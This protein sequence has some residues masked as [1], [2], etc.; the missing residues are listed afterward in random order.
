MGKTELIKAVAAKAETTIKNANEVVEATMAV[1]LESLK[2]GETITVPGFGKAKTR[3][4]G[5]RK[6]FNSLTKQDAV[7]PE[8]TIPSFTFSKKVKDYLNA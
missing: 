3:V 6:Y 2:D 4:R 7:M 5:E 1:V 8:A